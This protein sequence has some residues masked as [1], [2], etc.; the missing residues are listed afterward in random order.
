MCGLLQ[1]RS[2]LLL[3]F[4]SSALKFDVAALCGIVV[5]FM[6]KKN[7]KLIVIPAFCMYWPQK[8]CEITGT[9][10]TKITDS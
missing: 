1:N 8:L 2:R 5:L 3:V 9:G 4:S 10:N 6:M 7:K